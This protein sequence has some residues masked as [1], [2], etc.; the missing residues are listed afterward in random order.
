MHEQEIL[1]SDAPTLRYVEH[2]PLQDLQ[3]PLHESKSCLFRLLALLA[4]GFLAF[5][6]LLEDLES[7]IV[8]FEIKQILRRVI[9]PLRDEI[10]DNF[11]LPLLV[12]FHDASEVLN[13]LGQLIEEPFEHV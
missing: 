7:R 10:S 13:L 3:Y 2:E 12:A 4:L 8:A 11:F 9:L 6:L 1:G 5:L